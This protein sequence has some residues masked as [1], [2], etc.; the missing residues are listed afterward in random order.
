MGGVDRRLAVL[1]PHVHQ[2]VPLTRAAAAAGVPLRTAQRWLARYQSDGATGLSRGTRAD[3]GTRRFPAELVALV[4]GMVLRR[5]PP[6]LAELHRAVGVVAGQRGWPVPSYSVTRSIVAGVDPGMVAAAQRGTAAYRDRFELVMRRE[7]SSPN[8]CWQ[9]DHTELDLLIIDER[10]RP[11]RPWLTVVLDDRSRAVA[12]YTVFVGAPSAVQTALALRQ[13]IWRK[14]DPAWPVCGL[15]AAL[16][17]D[18]GADFTSGHIAQVC[19][20][21]RVQLIHFTPGSPRAAARSNG[22]SGR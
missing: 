3:A 19:A 2:G 12:G 22:S 18:N 21:T 13:A 1:E 11:V 20:D 7:A 14:T 17:S 6:K 16:Y 9:V 15:P 5:P 10:G 4:E 8:E